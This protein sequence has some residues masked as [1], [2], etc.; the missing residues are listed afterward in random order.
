[1]T[2]YSKDRQKHIINF[3]LSSNEIFARC[4]NIVE[5]EYFDS[6]LKAAVKYI[7]DYANENS[8]IPLFEDVNS[9]HKTAFTPVVGIVGHEESFLELVAEFCKHRA[10]ENVIRAAPPRLEK[11]EYSDIEKDMKSAIMISLQRDMGT[12]YFE[13]P[14]ERLERM[15]SRNA[16]ISSGWKEVDNKLYGGINRGE[17]T[18]FA[19][20]SGMGKSLFLQNLAINWSE[21]GL[22]VVYITFELSEELTAMRLDAM[23]NGIATRDVMKKIDDVELNLAMKRK[24][25]GPI[26]IKYM[27]SGT[28]AN[29]LKAYLRELEIKM[30]RKI[31]ALCIDYLDLMYPNNKK[32]NP[33]D[34]FIKDKFVSEELRGLA[35]EMGSLLVTASQLG[36]SAIEEAT[37]EQSHIAGGISKINTA[38]NVITIQ[39]SASMRERGEYKLQFLKTRSSSGVGS[40]ITLGFDPVTLRIFDAP[41]NA[42]SSSMP[43]SPSRA[44]LAIKEKLNASSTGGK[45][46]IVKESEAVSTDKAKDIKN[47]IKQLQLGTGRP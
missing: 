36:R 46:A 12:D 42:N 41:E 7:K 18:I 9:L 32:V 8:V 45:S 34:L 4:Q 24:S 35:V 16:T 20:N 15:R 33:S 47:M 44:A 3:L 37:H 19:G 38:D 40:Q 31:D 5:P 1:M 29:D 6:D 43:E 21:R 25:H 13:D 17:I 22:F 23:M 28:C 11:S 14:R 39:T 26:R 10:M 2:Q 30:N 27:P